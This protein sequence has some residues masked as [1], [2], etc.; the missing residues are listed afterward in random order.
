MTNISI[1]ACKA[2]TPPEFLLRTLGVA[3]QCVTC[4]LIQ[5]WGPLLEGLMASGS[6]GFIQLGLMMRFSV[7]MTTPLTIRS[8]SSLLSTHTAMAPRACHQSQCNQLKPEFPHGLSFLSELY[9]PQAMADLSQMNR[10]LLW[11]IC[12][13]LTSLF[14]F[15]S[16]LFS[17]SLPKI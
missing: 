1:I 12:E 14:C 4:Q 8:P 7:S 6:C 3:A 5:N 2:I 11:Q 9:L 10:K 13:F 16:N 17:C 15:Y